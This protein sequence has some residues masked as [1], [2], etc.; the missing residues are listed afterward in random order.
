[1]PVCMGTGSVYPCYESAVPVKQ[2][3]QHG[4][5]LFMEHTALFIGIWL[6]ELSIY[7]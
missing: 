1:M 5:K 3:S 7:M 6:P 2:R 4:W